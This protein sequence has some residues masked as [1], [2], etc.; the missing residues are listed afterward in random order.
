MMDSSVVDDFKLRRQTFFVKSYQLRYY[1]FT[2]AKGLGCIES[3]P[4]YA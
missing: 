3:N 4:G 2:R 1:R